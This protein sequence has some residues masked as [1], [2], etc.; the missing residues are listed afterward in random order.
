LSVP[1]LVS[2]AHPGQGVRDDAGIPLLG[3][4]HQPPFVAAIVAF[5]RIVVSSVLMTCLCSIGALDIAANFN[6]A[7]VEGGAMIW[8]PQEIEN[9]RALGFGVIVQE[10]AAG[11]SRQSTMTVESAASVAI[12][13]RYRNMIGGCS[14]RG[15]QRASAGKKVQVGQDEK[16]KSA[17]ECCYCHL[18]AT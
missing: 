13:K 10:A 6:F 5:W 16:V 2:V 11:T 9:L 7:D 14:R 3:F 18:Q 1:A 8:K 4:S 17:P 15:G 12:I